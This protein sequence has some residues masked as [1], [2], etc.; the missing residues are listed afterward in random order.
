M[1][2][3]IIQWNCRRIRAN[4]EELQ[5]LLEKYNPKVVC[6]QET[7]IKENNQININNYQA[8]NH[9]NIINSNKLCTLNNKSSTYLN[10]FTG[11]Y[12][13]IDLTLT[14][15]SSYMDYTW[16]VHNDLCGSDHFPIIIDILQPS[17]DNRPSRWKTNKA[18]WIDFKTLG[19]GQ[20]LYHINNTSMIDHFTETL[21]EIA[22]ET[23]PKTSP[24][25]K[26]STPWFN[27]ECR[28]VI[29]QRNA[30]LRKFN[31]EPS[32]SNLNTFKLL[33]AKA[34]KI[35]KQKKSVGKIMS[36]N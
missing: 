12:S 15:P 11:S 3:S 36:T 35:I 13:V 5:L 25:N 4:F 19:S 17:H 24:T 10:S 27:D 21:I 6:L 14:D 28:V 23:I 29:Q 1:P 26:R 22:S 2:N 31:K 9:L 7:F 16:K 18:N 30:A 34:R 20:V 33:R 8:Y 32:T